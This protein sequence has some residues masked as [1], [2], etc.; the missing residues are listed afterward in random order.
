MRDSENWLRKEQVKRRR[1]QKL[2]LAAQKVQW[3]A[4]YYMIIP[5]LMMSRKK[6]KPIAILY[7]RIPPLSKDIYEAQA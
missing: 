4:Q 1:R 5:P 7:D 2:T 6:V 3:I